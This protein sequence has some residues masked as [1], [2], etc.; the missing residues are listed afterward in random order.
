LT[1]NRSAWMANNGIAWMA[2]NRAVW[3]PSNRTTPAVVPMAVIACYAITAVANMATRSTMT[4]PAWVTNRT[5]SVV[6]ITVIAMMIMIAV[7][8]SMCSFIRKY[9]V[10]AFNH[11]C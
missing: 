10:V 3:M 5:T 6:P 11:R 7:M 1:N 4:P 2:K 9:L 8:T